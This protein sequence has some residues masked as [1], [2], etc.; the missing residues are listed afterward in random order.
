MLSVSQNFPDKNKSADV[1]CDVFGKKQWLFFTGWWRSDAFVVC[2]LL[3][4]IW[5]KPGS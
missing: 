2:K 3:P 1:Y 5:C 4:S